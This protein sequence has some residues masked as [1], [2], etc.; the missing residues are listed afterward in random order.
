[1]TNCDFKELLIKLVQVALLIVI[2]A[3]EMFAVVE[4]RVAQRIQFLVRFVALLVWL[5]V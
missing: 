1:M 5:G 2:A 3:K 4:F